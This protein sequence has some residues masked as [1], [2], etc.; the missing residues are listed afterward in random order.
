MN[1]RALL[2]V[3]GLGALAAA[4]PVTAGTG[5]ALPPRARASLGLNLAGIADWSSEI[6]FADAFK[7][8]RPW[9][10]QEEGKPFGQGPPLDLD[11]KGWV[12]SLRPRQYAESV[13]FIEF[14]DRWP[15]G[16][17]TC[18][19][20]GEGELDFTHDARVVTRAPGRLQV[21]IRPRSGQAFC[22]ITR[23]KPGNFLR[24]IR[25]LH[26]GTEQT[27]AQQPFLSE[28]L[29]RWRGFHC[30]RF[31]DWQATNNS[32]QAEWGERPTPDAQTQ[33]ARGVAVEHLVQLCNRLRIAPWFCMPHLA[34]DDYVREFARLVQS[35]LHPSL[36]IYLEH[37]NECWN[38]IFAQARHCRQRGR[39]LRLSDNDYEA[40]LR[41]HSQRSVEIF[42]IWQQ[43]FGGP[44]RLVRVL[45]AQSVN[46]WTGTTVMDWKNAHR[47][48]DALAIA[49][50]FGH[51]WG[52][53]ERA[54]ATAKLT[55]DAL[56]RELAE[57]VAESARSMAANA[58]E[59]KKRNLR[60]LA[61]EGGQHLAGYGGAENNESL[62]RLFHAANR[63][64]GM[65]ELYRR[66]LANWFAA[67]G[68]LYCVFSSMGTYSKWGSWGLLEHRKQ[69]PAT[70]PK[71][72]AVQEVLRG[73]S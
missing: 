56:V 9:I 26:P 44:R 43:V 22:R 29:Q 23:T 55:P 1:R 58:A 2:Q 38:G 54:E 62:T 69:D 10:S 27:A 25:L 67:G 20:E 50:Y 41:Y 66:D 51:R 48:A 4:P 49:P 53:P 47:E 64:P 11:A 3:V 14:G 31:M 24:N 21:E 17:F 19:Y 63:H 60:L 33:A 37:S 7:A 73:A 5:G 68:Q 61:Y 72:V 16:I 40:Q 70:A 59:A 32:Q 65:R 35:T 45:A 71:Y 6:V 34:T 13:V 12:R 57:D 46:P 28:F 36:P 39:E 30:F 8:S 15:E 52:S 42:R 18:R